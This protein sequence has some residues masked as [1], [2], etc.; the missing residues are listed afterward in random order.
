MKYVFAGILVGLILMTVGALVTVPP[1]DTGNRRTL[2]WVTDANPARK[3]QIELFEAFAPELTAMVDSGNLDV[4]KVIVQS[5]GGVGPDIMDCYSCYQTD[6]YVRTGIAWDIT[7]R[8][9]ELGITPELCWPGARNTMTV[10]GRQYTFPTNCGVMG[11]FYNKDIFDKEEMPYPKADWTWEEFVDVARKLTKKKAGGKGY[12]RF[13]LAGY[14]YM[15]AVWQAGGSMYSE[16]GTRCVLDSVEAR[17]GWHFWNDLRVKWDIVPDAVEVSGMAG[18]SASYGGGRSGLFLGGRYALLEG[19]RWNQITWREENASRAEKTLKL[20]KELAKLKTQQGES[21]RR[22]REIERKLSQLRPFRYGVVGM[23]IKRRRASRFVARA[24]AINRKSDRRED[25]LTF[26]AFLASEPYCHD[27][28]V[29]A[30]GISAVM[31]YSQTVDQVTNPDYPNERECDEVW[32][33]LMP[34]GIAMETSPFVI[35]DDAGRIV[36]EYTSAIQQGQLEVDEAVD[37]MTKDVNDKIAK[38]VKTFKHLREE[39]E[40]RTGRKVE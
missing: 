25:G 1:R 21:D 4:S 31:K 20:K 34:S 35:P 2:V 9:K 33:E 5:S 28:N 11:I 16:D 13:A 32:I 26:L 8:A 19:G 7:D 22:V 38:N 6:T 15:A 40:R 30:D 29:T 36:N 23:P 37:R 39:Y 27:I 14:T 10:G 17:E 18:E 12:D 24:T 3:S